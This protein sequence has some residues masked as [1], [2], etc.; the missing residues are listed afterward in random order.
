[1]CNFFVINDKNGLAIPKTHCYNEVEYTYNCLS[2]V[3]TSYF[4]SHPEQGVSP[5][6][7]ELPHI[8]NVTEERG[9]FGALRLLG[10]TERGKNQ[11]KTMQVNE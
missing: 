5:Q 9:F 3:E 1:M 10:M 8:E 4:C 6:S 2:A 11:R 7:R